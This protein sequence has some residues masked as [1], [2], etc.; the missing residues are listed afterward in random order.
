MERPRMT[1]I[2]LPEAALSEPGGSE[3][4]TVEA[5]Q[6]NVAKTQFFGSNPFAVGKDAG[7]ADD[8]FAASGSTFR[9]HAIQSRTGCHGVI[10]R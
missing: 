7:S 9:Y 3:L 5:R 4:A 6:Q 2:P 10:A 1:Q 8:P